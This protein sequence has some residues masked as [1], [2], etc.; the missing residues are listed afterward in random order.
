MFR[1]VLIL[2]LL[3]SGVAHARPAA[4]GPVETQ[5]RADLAR[6]AAMDRAGPRLNSVIALNPH[7]IA[8]A[9]AL[10]FPLRIIAWTMC[11]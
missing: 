6:I 4:G 1:T 9:C 11:S 5:V 7:A 10:V 8:D 3:A 2:A